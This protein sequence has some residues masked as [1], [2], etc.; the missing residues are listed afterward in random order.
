MGIPTPTAYAKLSD[1]DK[2]ALTVLRDHYNGK[3][4]IDIIT[5]SG[6]VRL[7]LDHGGGANTGQLPLDYA[8]DVARHDT[9][10]RDA[11]NEAGL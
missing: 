1:D 5:R 6:E 11:L 3:P 4:P 10:L 9:A 7:H 8:R 2:S